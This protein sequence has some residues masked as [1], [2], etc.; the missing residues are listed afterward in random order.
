MSSDKVPFQC[1]ISSEARDAIRRITKLWGRSQANLVE[2]V[3]LNSQAAYLGRMSPNEQQRFLKEELSK[4]EAIEIFR[5]ATNGL[6]HCNE[7]PGTPPP[8]GG[9]AA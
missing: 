2:R 7:K 4:T 3:F 5:R 1:Q 6:Y 8:F 9:S